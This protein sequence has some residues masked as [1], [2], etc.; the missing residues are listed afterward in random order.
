MKGEQKMKRAT[1]VFVAIVLIMSLCASA[2]AAVDNDA[3]VIEPLGF[4]DEYYIIKINNTTNTVPANVIVGSGSGVGWVYVTSGTYVGIAQR[5]LN[6]IN[7]YYYVPN[8]CG[9]AVDLLYGPATI[10][11]I[12]NFQSRFGLTQDGV[13]GPMSWGKFVTY[14]K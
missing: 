6:N 11:A 12:K 9:V 14:C 7:N 5:A 8:G 1:S 3:E 10:A 2:F 4:D 13:V